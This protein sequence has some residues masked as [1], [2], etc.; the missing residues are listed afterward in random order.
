MESVAPS[1]AKDYQA[2][3]F[4]RVALRSTRGYIPS[5]LRGDPRS[6]GL[7]YCLC[8]SRFGVSAFSLFF[9]LSETSLR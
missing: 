7:T 2:Y 1:G 9:T 8:E 5:P 4:P 3:T 6:Q